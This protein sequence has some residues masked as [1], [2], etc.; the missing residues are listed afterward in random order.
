M[1][2]GSILQLINITKPAANGRFLLPACR[3]EASGPAER[4]SLSFGIYH[5]LSIFIQTFAVTGQ[6]H[7]EVSFRMFG[8]G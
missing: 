7:S 8:T 5:Q 6:R 1:V 3:P 4:T 2:A